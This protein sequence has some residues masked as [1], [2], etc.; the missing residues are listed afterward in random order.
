MPP[1][2]AETPAAHI[3]DLPIYKYKPMNYKY[4]ITTLT[5]ILALTACGGGGDSSSDSPTN[6]NNPGD[7]SGAPR[8]AIRAENSNANSNGPDVRPHTDGKSFA[9]DPVLLGYVRR[10][11]T[12]INGTLSEVSRAIYI[13]NNTFEGMCSQSKSETDERR[14]Y[15][16]PHRNTMALPKR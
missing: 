10:Y 8:L 12:L 3:N 9:R 15:L 11:Y 7:G 2:P 5:F 6:L 14:R 16:Y 1:G 13:A 4:I